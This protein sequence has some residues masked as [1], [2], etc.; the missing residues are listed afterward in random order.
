MC[1]IIPK[2]PTQGAPLA[3]YID[4]GIG[5]AIQ[6]NLQAEAIQRPHI[7]IGKRHIT[8]FVIHAMDMLALISL[9]LTIAVFRILIIDVSQRG[10]L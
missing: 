9:P 7:S 1:H 3:F 10:L 4:S 5:F 8:P 6:S 2:L